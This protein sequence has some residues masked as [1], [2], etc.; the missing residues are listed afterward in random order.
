MADVTASV[1]GRLT[2]LATDV[3]RAQAR[4]SEAEKE[5]ASV[6]AELAVKLEQLEQLADSNRRNG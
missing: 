2:A 5:A 4:T 3:E 1:A 6:A